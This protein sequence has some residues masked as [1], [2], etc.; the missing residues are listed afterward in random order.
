MPQLFQSSNFPLSGAGAAAQALSDAGDLKDFGNG[1]GDVAQAYKDN[2]LLSTK[3]S[4]LGIDDQRAIL[5]GAVPMPGPVGPDGKPTVIS[6]SQNTV[7]DLTHRHLAAKAGGDAMGA[8]TAPTLEQILGPSAKTLPDQVKPYAGLPFPIAEKMGPLMRAQGVQQPQ[9]HVDSAALEKFYKGE[10]PLPSPMSVAAVDGTSTPMD[11]RQYRVAQQNANYSFTRSLKATDEDRAVITDA[12]NAPQ[13]RLTLQQ[14]QY[15]GR[16]DAGSKLLAKVL[17]KDP[18]KSFYDQAV[19]FAGDVA[20]SRAKGTVVGGA[21]TIAAAAAGTVDD[22]L[23]E[24]EGTMDSLP[25]SSFKVF[26][27]AYLSGASSVNDPDANK[28]LAL[29]NEL[30]KA[31]AKADKGGTGSPTDQD[32]KRAAQTFAS[33]LN[34]GGVQAVRQAVDLVNKSRAKRLGGKDA[35]GS[36]PGS[37]SAAGPKIIKTQAEYDALPKGARY[38]DSDGQPGVK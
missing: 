35:T 24:L 15:Y 37:T 22:I 3:L 5:Y 28:A 34:K 36:A 10:G 26:N 32:V 4:D 7:R 1:L 31:Q 29:F 33:S 6:P 23:N 2:K 19:N 25:Q 14:A 17:A 8:A 13:P 12:L 9:V 16:S 20:A 38:Q 27:K 21:G 18:S 11:I 30:A